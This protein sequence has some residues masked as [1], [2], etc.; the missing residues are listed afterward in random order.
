MG[1]FARLGSGESRDPR[2]SPRDEAR[3]WLSLRDNEWIVATFSDETGRL[4][5][6]I[7]HLGEGSWSADEAE[8][9][10]PFSVR[11]FERLMSAGGNAVSVG[12]ALAERVAASRCSDGIPDTDVAA[13]LDVKVE[14]RGRWD[15]QMRA[16]VAPSRRGGDAAVLMCLNCRKRQ[17]H[18]FQ[19]ARRLGGRS[20]WRCQSCSSD[21]RSR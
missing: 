9:R 8:W 3:L 6:L 16:P 10:F 20:Y 12:P 1:I 18:I 11:I 17:L 14:L 21:Q 7:G 19:L 2:P 15:E 13:G 5:N 4:P